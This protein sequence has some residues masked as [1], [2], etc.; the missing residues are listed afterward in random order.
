MSMSW[1]LPAAPTLIWGEIQK[2]LGTP[3]GIVTIVVMVYVFRDPRK[4]RMQC[5]FGFETF[6]NLEVISC[7]WPCNIHTYIDINQQNYIGGATHVHIRY[8]SKNK[9]K[10]LY[11]TFNFTIYESTFALVKTCAGELDLVNPLGHPRKP[12]FFS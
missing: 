12:F 11:H 5:Q 4:K 10:V 9:C 1:S 7:S 8:N 6:G 2:G 3:T